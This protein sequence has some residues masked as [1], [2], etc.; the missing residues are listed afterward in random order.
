MISFWIFDFRFSI[1]RSTS[2]FAFTLYGLLFV[3]CVSAQAQQ[4]VKIPRIGFL[5]NRVR[6]SVTTPD[7]FEDA[8]RDGLRRLGYTEGKNIRI[9]YRYAEGAEERLPTLVAEL[10]KLE[11]DLIFSATLRGL[12][13]AKQANKTIPIVIVTTADPIAAGLVNNLAH[14]KGNITGITRYTRDL[15]G[16]RLEVLKEVIPEARRVGVLGSAASNS[17]RDTGIDYYEAAAQRLKLEVLPF[18]VHGPKPDFEKPFRS[19]RQAKVNAIV[20]STSAVTISHRK[21]IAVLAISSRIAS[22]CERDDYVESGCLISYS[23]DEA[24][25]Y[26]R[27][28][29]YVD[30]IL[31]GAKPADL[32]IEQPTKFEL[33]INLKTTKQIGLIIPPNVLARADRV[34][35]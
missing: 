2:I 24:E 18:E 14:P 1:G 9:E 28:A 35:R 5:S 19:A 32:P 31:K 26:R 12:R 25:S 29:V 7:L 8:F 3:L 15:S 30:R 21:A 6:P 23:A 27:A 11:V 13:A 16:K 17:M 22:M 10:I 34:I 4:L 33:V 20:I